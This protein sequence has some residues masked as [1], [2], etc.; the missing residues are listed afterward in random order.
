MKP[1]IWIVLLRGVN[2]GGNNPLPMKD[3]KSLLGKSGYTDVATYI[4]SGNLVLRTN[5]T[6]ANEISDEIA[7]AIEKHYGF[8]PGVIAFQAS[9]VAKVIA[10]NPFKTSVSEPKTLHAFFLAT[11]PQKANVAALADLK[12]S[13]ES[14]EVTGKTMYLHAPDGIGRSKLAAKAE[15]TLGVEASGRNWRTVAKLHEMATT[16]DG[17]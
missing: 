16:L 4:Q 12:A 6:S 11:K 7:T 10:N 17:V 14:Y 13:S 2:V 5:Q 15:K 3:L 1:R 8:R 9:E